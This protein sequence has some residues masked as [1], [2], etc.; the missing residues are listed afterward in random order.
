MYIIFLGR[1]D[2]VVVIIITSG[3]TGST[4]LTHVIIL[5]CLFV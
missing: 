3:K 2:V 5:L 1:D 4:V